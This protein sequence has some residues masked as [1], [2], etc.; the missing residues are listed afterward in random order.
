M[1]SAH[2]R[3][4]TTKGR[5][6][7]RRHDQLV[8][9]LPHPLLRHTAIDERGYVQWPNLTERQRQV[10][11]TTR[12]SSRRSAS[13]HTASSSSGSRFLGSRWPG[14][15]R[16]SRSAFSGA[17]LVLR[18]QQVHGFAHE[19]ALLLAGALLEDFEGGEIFV[20]D[21]G[22]HGRGFSAGRAHATPTGS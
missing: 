8:A 14:N 6:L 4:T 13:S 12:F 18:E 19:F 11:R 21:P 5:P 15:R 17:D 2:A 7:G 9:S 16:G 3:C 20:G 1:T 10:A 22:A